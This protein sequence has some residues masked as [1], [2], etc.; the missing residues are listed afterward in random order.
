M[1]AVDARDAA[2]PM[3]HVFAKANIR[4]RDE[5]W[6]SLFDCAQRFLDHAVLR[7]SAARLLIFLVGD[8]KK[9]NGLESCVPRRASLIDNLVDGELEDAGHT[10]NRAAFVDLVTDEKR[11][12]EIVRRQIR[13]AD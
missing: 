1:F 11:E 13:F 2:M 12:N 9:Q 3:A 6:T 5:L 7:V 4:D 10:R 8:S